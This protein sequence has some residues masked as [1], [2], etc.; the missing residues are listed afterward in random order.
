[1]NRIFIVKLSIKITSLSYPYR[2][3]WWDHDKHLENNDH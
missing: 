3:S 1:M 2:V